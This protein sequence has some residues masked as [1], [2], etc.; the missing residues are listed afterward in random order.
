[1]LMLMLLFPM[2]H[3]RVCGDYS[4]IFSGVMNTLGSPPPVRGLP[5]TGIAFKGKDRI[6]PACAGTTIT[7]DISTYL[8]EDHPCMCG[9]YLMDKSL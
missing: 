7:R 2:D 6:T 8:L 3:P 9:D 5:H 4:I 1:M